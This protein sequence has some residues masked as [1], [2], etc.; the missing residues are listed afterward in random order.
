MQAHAMKKLF[1]KYVWLTY[2]DELNA[3]FSHNGS[4][5]CDE[6]ALAEA[7]QGL[8]TLGSVPSD[9]RVRAGVIF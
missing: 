5:Q 7:A 3:L 1:P 4:I 8:L 6:G 9:A 2:S